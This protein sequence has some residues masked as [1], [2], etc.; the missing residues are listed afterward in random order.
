MRKL[1]LEIELNESA[2]KDLGPMFENIHSFEIL[3][4]LKIDYEEGI[5]VDLVEFHLKEG[6]SIQDMKFVGK[7]EI[8]SILKSQDNKHICLVKYTESE[9]SMGLFQ[10]SDLDLINTTPI[11]VS[12]DRVTYSCIGENENLTKLVEIIKIHAGN[13]TNMTFK[14][15]AYQK[16]DIISVLTDKQKEILNTAHKQGYYKYPRKIKTEELAKKI[17]ISKGTAIEH[18]RKGEERLMDI[19][20]A[21][22]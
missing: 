3:E 10:E 22:Y 15:A 11:K 8:I 14:K 20:F 21:G 1:T 4:T 7:M 9:E 17:G 18:L 13:I 6:F 5:C 16:H 12:E 19:I 2:K